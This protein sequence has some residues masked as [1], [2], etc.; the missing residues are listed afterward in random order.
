MI[1]IPEAFHTE[2][3]DLPFADDLTETS[4]Q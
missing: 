1:S 3:D 4:R 2:T